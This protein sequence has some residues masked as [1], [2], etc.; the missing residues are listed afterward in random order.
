MGGGLTVVQPLATI[1][2]ATEEDL[3][4]LV[5]LGLAFHAGSPYRDRFSPTPERMRATAAWVLANGALFLAVREAPVGMMGAVVMPD[6][7]AGE[8]YGSELFW[9]VNPDARGLGLRLLR[10]A[11][12]WARSQG[13]VKFV[14]VAPDRRAEQLYERLH[15]AKTETVWER[16]LLEA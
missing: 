13:A 11:E 5:S 16:R 1:R 15:Y 2:R 10:E 8:L 9:W 6:L 7:F 3:D 12:R 14:L 4:A